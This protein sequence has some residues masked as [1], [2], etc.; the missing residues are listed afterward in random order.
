VSENTFKRVI[1]L[2]YAYQGHPTACSGDQDTRDRIR[3]ASTATPGALAQDR[4]F[5][6]MPPRLAAI[7]IAAI[8]LYL[9]HPARPVLLLRW[10][11]AAPSPLASAVPYW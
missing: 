6:E 5:P 7:A 8:G 10:T 3:F 1:S 11:G 2:V 4:L 9:R